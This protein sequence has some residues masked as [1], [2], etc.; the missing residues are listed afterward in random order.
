MTRAATVPVPPGG[1]ARRHRSSAGIHQRRAAAPGAEGRRDPLGAGGGHQT[2]APT[3]S[4]SGPTGLP[5]LPAP[6]H[7]H[8]QVSHLQPPR[9]LQ[10]PLTSVTAQSAL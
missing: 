10:Q 4:P 9:Q 3:H 1:A 5:G 8:S 6:L 7:A 2:G